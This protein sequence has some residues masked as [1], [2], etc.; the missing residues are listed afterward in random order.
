MRRLEGREEEKLAAKFRA[1][2]VCL[3]QER[4]PQRPL[5]CFGFSWGRELWLPIIEKV[6]EA[7]IPGVR[8]LSICA[9]LGC[10]GLEQARS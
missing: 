7:S 3:F 6:I 10:I 9:Y 5:D 8:Q 2:R 4:D 1:C